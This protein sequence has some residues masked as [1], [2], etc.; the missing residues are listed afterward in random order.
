[1]S[2][3]PVSKVLPVQASKPVA[4]SPY[5]N[6]FQTIPVAVS[7]AV[8]SKDDFATLWERINGGDKK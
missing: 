2:F 1:M 4:D 3:I 6:S 8:N 5:K 7:E